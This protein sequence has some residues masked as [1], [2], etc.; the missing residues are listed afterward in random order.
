MALYDTQKYRIGWKWIL[1]EAIAEFNI[2]FQPIRYFAYH[3]EP[4]TIFVLLYNSNHILSSL[5]EICNTKKSSGM[6]HSNISFMN[7]RPVSSLIN[8]YGAKL[9]WRNCYVKTLHS[10]CYLAQ[11][12]SSQAKKNRKIKKS[13]QRTKFQSIAYFAYLF[14]KLTLIY[15]KVF[16][17]FPFWHN[18]ILN[19]PASNAH[20]LLPIKVPARVN[21]SRNGKYPQIH[22]LQ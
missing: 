20:N 15:V 17:Y 13:T 14:M 18:F 9:L 2:H 8:C 11:T 4:K 19:V 7:E 1:N 10:E 22:F 16:K 3:I 12:I 6:I 5:P 21:I